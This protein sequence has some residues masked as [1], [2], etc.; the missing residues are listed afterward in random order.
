MRTIPATYG[1]IYIQ[2]SPGHKATRNLVI[3]ENKFVSKENDQLVAT[4]TADQNDLNQFGTFND[5]YYCRPIN[6]NGTIVLN[7]SGN[8][9][10][11][12]A[13][14]KS[15][16]KQDVS[17]KKSPKTIS[18][19]AGLRFEYNATSSDKTINLGATYMDVTGK[20]YTGSMTLAPYSSV[21]LI[22]IS[23]TPV[24]ITNKEGQYLVGAVLLQMGLSLLITGQKSQR[25]T[26]LQHVP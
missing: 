8:Q 12:L 23:G 25:H 15:S 16:F 1:Q 9:T 20:T 26:S 6:D 13:G 24:S 10:T 11:N 5:N 17:S 14:W 3:T 22:Y 19:T 2:S 7:S 21:V 4:F 18:N